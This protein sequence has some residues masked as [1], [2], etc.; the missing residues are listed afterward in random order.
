MIWYV[1]VLVVSFP[2]HA[3]PVWPGMLG[4][5]VWTHAADWV[6]AGYTF[7]HKPDFLG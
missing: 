1:W 7:I 5:S 3:R 2:G 4:F 6:R